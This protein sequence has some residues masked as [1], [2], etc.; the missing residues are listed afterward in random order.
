MAVNTTNIPDKL[1]FKRSEVIKIARLEGRVIDYWQREFGA[2]APM[3]NRQGEMIYSRKDLEIIFKIKQWMVAQRIDKTKVKEMLRRGQ[4]GEPPS[5]AN[6]GP[7]IRQIPR[8]KLRFIRQSLQ[9][10]LTILE[11]HDKK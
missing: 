2:F 10:I 11:K 3:V 8:E 5:V 9:D 7:E 1:T 4:E 6:P